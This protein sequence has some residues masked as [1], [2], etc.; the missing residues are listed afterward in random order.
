MSDNPYNPK[1][2]YC[3]GTWENPAMMSDDSYSTFRC[4][5]PF[6]SEKNK[7]AFLKCECEEGEKPAVNCW[8]CT[9]AREKES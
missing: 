4:P 1:C 7:P 2:S 5:F 8:K 3:G 6:H 9:Y